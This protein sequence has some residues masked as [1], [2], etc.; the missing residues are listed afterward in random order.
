MFREKDF[1]VKFSLWAKHNL[2]ESCAFELKIE[3]G[4]ALPFSALAVHQKENLL[5]VKHGSPLSFVWKIM[6]AGY[7]N[8]FDGFVLCDASAWIAVM[9][10]SRG[11]KKFYLIDIDAWCKEEETSDRKSLTEERAEAIGKTCYLA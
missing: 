5:A 7:Q 8:P 11:C 4:N 2:D 3:K 10:Y 1:Q 9:F 6:D